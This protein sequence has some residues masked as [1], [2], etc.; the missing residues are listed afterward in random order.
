VT[1]RLATIREAK[2][3]W[4]PSDRESE[5]FKYGLV[6]GYRQALQDIQTGD[7]AVITT[8]LRAVADGCRSIGWCEGWNKGYSI[9]AQQFSLVLNSEG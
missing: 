9:Q 6:E 4:P 1:R 3:I 5:E 2:R 7:L 8:R